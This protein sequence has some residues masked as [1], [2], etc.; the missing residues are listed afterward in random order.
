M[1]LFWSEWQNDIRKTL[2]ELPSARSRILPLMPVTRVAAKGKEKPLQKS[3]AGV[4]GL[5]ERPAAP[6]ADGGLKI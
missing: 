5:T 6:Q 4:K 1:L 3:I 2:L